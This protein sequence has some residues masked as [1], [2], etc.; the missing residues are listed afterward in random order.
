MPPRRPRLA[1]DVIYVGVLRR[2]F[3][4]SYYLAGTSH[5]YV[6]PAQPWSVFPMA[7][8][9]G[10]LGDT[11]NVIS[12][13]STEGLRLMSV[14]CALLPPGN[15]L[16]FHFVVVLRRVVHLLVQIVSRHF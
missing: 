15:A 1:G 16:E 8:Q 3:R 9:D 5:F 11:T 13:I 12:S 14:L 7:M 4:F 2:L 10:A 6:F